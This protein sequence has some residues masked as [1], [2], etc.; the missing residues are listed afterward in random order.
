[1][2]IYLKARVPPFFELILFLFVFVFSEYAVSFTPSQNDEG[3]SVI[4]NNTRISNII[5]SYSRLLINNCKEKYVSFPIDC[6]Y[7]VQL[8][9]WVLLDHMQNLL[10]L[11]NDI[12][13]QLIIDA[14]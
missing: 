9:H 14:R 3:C 2:Y 11:K 7:E 6:I 5:K 4:R 1:M 13:H 10:F 8:N 12:L